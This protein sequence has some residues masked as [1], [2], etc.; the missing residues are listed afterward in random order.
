MIVSILFLFLFLIVISALLFFIFLFLIPSLKAQNINTSSLV[1]SRLEENV[2]STIQET[3]AEKAKKVAIIKSEEGKAADF[4]Y[5][6]IKDCWI[7]FKSF[8]KG[9]IYKN[10][11]IGFGSCIK[12]CTRNAIQLVNNNAR[13][14]AFCDGCGECLSSCPKKLITL[15]ERQK[16]SEE[17]LQDKGKLFKLMKK[18]YRILRQDKA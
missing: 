8:E 11:C 5:S 15:M 1:F 13:I 16:K 3:P 7:Y 4:T 18:W 10:N 17:S 12:S 6:G 9:G 2:L 14:T